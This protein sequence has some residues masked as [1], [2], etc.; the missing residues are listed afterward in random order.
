MFGRFNCNIQQCNLANFH[1]CSSLL[2]KKNFY[3]VLGVSSKATKSQIK[4]SYYQ[5]SLRYHPDHNKDDVK[6]A[7][8]FREITEAYEVLGDVAKRRLYDKG[9]YGFASSPVSDAETAMHS[10]YYRSAQRKTP[11]VGRTHAYNFDAWTQAHYQE[12]FQRKQREKKVYEEYVREKKEQR[13]IRKDKD[14]PFLLLILLSLFAGFGYAS[15]RMEKK[16][17]DKPR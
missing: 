17:G 4:K 1:I 9:L 8:K 12:S 11:S 5:L 3:D 14:A 16:Y 10:K 13:E 7:N 15:L 6:A 2:N